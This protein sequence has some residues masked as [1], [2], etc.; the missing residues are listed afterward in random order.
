M[1]WTNH[2][3]PHHVLTQLARHHEVRCLFNDWTVREESLE[4]GRLIV[5]KKAFRSRY[6][7]GPLVY[8]FSIPEKID[9]LVRHFLRPDLLVFEL[10]D[11]PEKEFAGWKAKLPR[12][13]RRADVIRTTHPAITDY[14]H[15]EFADDLGDKQVTTSFNGVDLEMFDPDRPYERPDVLRDVE[16]PVLGF[17]GNLDSW[18][19]WDLIAE[20]ASLSEYQVVVIGGTEGTAP[21]VPPAL[22]ASSVIW[23]DKRPIAEIPGFL[24]CF[25]VALFPFV[26]NEMTDAV[27]PLKVWEYLSFGKPVLA[28]P[29]RF[30]REHAGVLEL[31]GP[32][33]VEEAVTR[34]MTSRN[35][36]TKVA[37]RKAAA[38]AR[39]WRVVADDLHDEI[40]AQ[41]YPDSG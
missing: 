31:V 24:S 32:A 23:V 4:D 28:T 39:D 1:L 2:Q 33:G 20:L 29:T 36:P 13:L 35:D 40:M 18:I 9:Y 17:Y 30:A 19:D 37:A 11:L 8:Y 3:R 5:T 22:L 41:L 26:V 16:K 12:A 10:M 15:R 21:K 38:A 14:L 34:A 6:H 27:D 25:D 7:E